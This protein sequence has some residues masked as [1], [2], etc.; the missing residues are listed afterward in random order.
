MSSP[1]RRLRCGE[2]DYLAAH[3][4]DLRLAQRF[5]ARY[6]PAAIRELVAAGITPEQ[7]NAVEGLNATEIVR[8]LSPQEAADGP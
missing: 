6:G 8:L 2:A 1:P 3:G 7:A 4:I 5:A